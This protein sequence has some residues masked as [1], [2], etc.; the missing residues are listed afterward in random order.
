MVQYLGKC[1]S[2]IAGTEG[3]HLCMFAARRVTQGTYYLGIVSV[4]LI[5][6]AG[7]AQRSKRR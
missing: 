6:E 7:H 1:R 3:L 4:L 2:S 5:R